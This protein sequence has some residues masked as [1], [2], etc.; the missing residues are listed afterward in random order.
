[1]PRRRSKH[2]SLGNVSP[3]LLRGD[4][5]KDDRQGRAREMVAEFCR[6]LEGRVHR[7]A[8]GSNGGNGAGAALRPKLSRRMNQ[9]LRHLLGGDSE[10]QIARKL[11]LSPHT[12]HVYVKALYRDFGVSSR[13]ELLARFVS[14]G[15][16]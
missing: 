8:N 10:K 13:G 16:E 1:M 9:T 3:L 11:S 14:R 15:N 5:E 4:A 7:S 12:I 2:P 6:A